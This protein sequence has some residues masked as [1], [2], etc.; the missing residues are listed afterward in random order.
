MAFVIWDGAKLAA[1]KDALGLVLGVDRA[2][3]SHACISCSPASACR[4]RWSTE[5]GEKEYNLSCVCESC[6]DCLHQKGLAAWRFDGL[7]PMG[8]NLIV[9][10][11]RVIKVKRSVKIPPAESRTLELWV[12]GDLAWP[13]LRKPSAAAHQ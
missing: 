2:R 6:F 8:V 5:N 9:L 4:Q 3:A 13:E 7:T 10:W 12:R 1:L 11:V